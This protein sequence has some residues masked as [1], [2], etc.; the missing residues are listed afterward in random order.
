MRFDPCGMQ[1]DN[2]RSCYRTV[3]R[4][5]VDSD[6]E[7]TIRWYFCA[8]DAQPFPYRHLFSSLIW[9]PDYDEGTE[10]VDPG[11]VRGAPR[12]WCNGSPPFPLGFEG[13]KFCGPLEY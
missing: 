10:P 13:T 2:M 3:M 8:P 1:M 4:P 6:V 9:S 12:T 7:V 5:F 11:E